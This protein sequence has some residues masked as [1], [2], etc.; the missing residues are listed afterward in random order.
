MSYASSTSRPGQDD[1]YSA[2][3]TTEQTTPISARR[4]HAPSL[5][6][7]SQRGRWADDRKAPRLKLAVNSAF[8]RSDSMKTIARIKFRMPY[9][10]WATGEFG[11]R[12]SAVASASSASLSLPR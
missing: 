3:T 2:A 6:T 12:L 7:H 4:L 11:T 8:T 10:K 1:Q 9:S 5:H